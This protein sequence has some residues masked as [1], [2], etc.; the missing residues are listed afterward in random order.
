MN[1]IVMEY[2][3]RMP[4]GPECVFPGVEIR[5][6]FSPILDKM[7]KNTVTLNDSRI[8]YITSRQ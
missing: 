6:I 8:K 3:R 1:E 4:R 2:H 5:K 7:R